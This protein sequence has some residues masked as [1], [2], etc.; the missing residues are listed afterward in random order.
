MQPMQKGMHLQ[1]H[2][3]LYIEWDRKLVP[4]P[5][6]V[7]P[8]L[9]S[10]LGA[11]NS[12][13]FDEGETA[14]PLPIE[15]RSPHFEIQQFFDVEQALPRVRGDSPDSFRHVGGQAHHQSRSRSRIDATAQVSRLALFLAT[16]A[17]LFSP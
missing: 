12:A 13:A 9:T 8:L 10:G 11:P 7:S 14:H 6:L 4:C 1:Y 15:T 17:P 5:P 2:L 3:L 16:S